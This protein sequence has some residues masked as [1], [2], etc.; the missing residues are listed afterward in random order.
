LEI[1]NLSVN[2]VLT[3]AIIYEAEGADLAGHK[4]DEIAINGSEDKENHNGSKI[5]VPTGGSVPFVQNA[6]STPALSALSSLVKNWWN[7]AAYDNNPIADRIIQGFVCWAA[8]PDAYLFDRVLYYHVQNLGKKAFVQLIREVRRL[9]TTVVFADQNRLLLQTTKSQVE[10][11][12][13]FAKFVIKTLRSKPLFSFLDIQ[14]TQYWDIVLWMDQYNYCGRGCKEIRESGT[15]YQTILSWQLKK[16][17]PE[18]L[19]SEFEDWSVYFLEKL[20]E[21]KAATPVVGEPGRLTQISSTQLNRSPNGGGADG[22]DAPPFGSGIFEEMDKPIVN[23]MKQLY[24][25]YQEGLSHAE[26]AEQFQFPDVPSNIARD[27]SPIAML[28]KS[29]CGVFG[30]AKDLSIEFRII[31]RRLL[32]VVGLAEFSDEAAFKNPS[33]SLRLANVTCEHC[34]YVR[35]VDL[36]RDDYLLVQSGSSMIHN[37]VCEVCGKDYNRITL[38]ERLIQEIY[39]LMALYQIQDLRCTKCRRIRDDDMSQ[40][41]ECSGSWTETIPRSSILRTMDTYRKAATYLDLRL[42]GGVLETLD[43]HL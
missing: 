5:A 19:Q 39:K 18:V 9:G 23:R 3:A 35:D 21:H 32:N 37:W 26:I 42:V 25:R 30:L 28:I 1:R 2:T 24:R 22:E 14:V 33:L 29:L 16:F 34:G 20:V 27:M 11:T 8:S 12:Y 38:E 7:E 10:N 6:F 17:L 40:H 31:R 36:L 13:A 43:M 4:I 15:Q 41:C